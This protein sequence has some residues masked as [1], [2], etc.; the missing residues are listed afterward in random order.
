MSD[1]L[2]DTVTLLIIDDD[3][4]DIRGVTRA[5][6][7]HRFDN[8][9][10]TAENGEEGLKILRGTPENAPLSRPYL[11]LLDLNMP[12]M[13]GL[14]F[15]DELRQDQALKDSVVFVLTTSEDDRDMAL[16][17]NKQI[18]GYIVKSRAGVDFLNLVSMLEKFVLTVR[19]PENPVS[20]LTSDDNTT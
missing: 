9:I 1:S 15:L 10:I 19:F 8:P 17:Y 3:T 5:L 11:I 18:A 12:R 4:V 14:E 13:N 6:R 16:A 2:K 7:R 20:R